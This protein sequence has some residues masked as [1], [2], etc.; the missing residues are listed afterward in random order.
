MSEIVAAG[1]KAL[2]SLYGGKPG[3][4]L[5]ALRYQRYFKKLATKTAH[6]QP[7]QLRPTASA[8]RYHSL[9]IYLQVKQWKGEDP[10]NAL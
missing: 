4:G 2:V 8:V 1:E 6:I 7:Q 3:V 10:E 5:T 9:R